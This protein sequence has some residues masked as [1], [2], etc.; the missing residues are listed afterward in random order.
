MDFMDKAGGALSG[1]AMGAM[2]GS[3][4]GPVGAAIGGVL[5]AIGG[6]VMAFMGA[7]KKRMERLKKNFLSLVQIC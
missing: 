3:F 1:A 5:G 2:M 7:E 6:L 4:L